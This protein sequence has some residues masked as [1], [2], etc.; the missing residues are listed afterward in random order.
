MSEYV[1]VTGGAGYIGAHT[2]KEL[3]AHGYVPVVYDNF[4]TGHMDFVRYGEFCHGDVT[5]TAKLVELILQKKPLGVIHFA[6]FINV[7]ESV[8]DPGK[9]YVNNLHGTLSLLEAMRVTGLRAIVVSG[10][11][12]VYGETEAERVGEET[13]FNPM[14]PYAASKAFMERFLDD[15]GA[16]YGFKS[17]VLRY[18]NASGADGDAEL[19]ERHKPET[20]LIP[21]VF[22][23]ACG[24]I[25]ALSVFGTDYPTPDGTCLRDYIHVSDLAVAHRL[26]LEKLLAGGQS[27]KVNLGTGTGYSVREIVERCGRIA[28]K[29]IPFTLE[30]RRAGD[31]PS[32]VA[33]VD[34]AKKIL[35]WIPCHSS[36]D[37]ILSTAWKWF[38]KDNARAF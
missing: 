7:G 20:H 23:A 9:Y 15:Y 21:R 3:A 33:R 11:C 38:E 26:A 5:D 27:F 28:G 30:G 4:V 1:L 17:A 12:A 35:G 32:L 8:L 37:N 25:P 36:L 13:P 16:A 22:M 34:A 6:S 31:V 18:F 2:C 24:L 10:T 14:N 19:G 29:K